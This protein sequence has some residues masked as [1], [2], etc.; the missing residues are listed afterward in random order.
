MEHADDHFGESVAASYD[1][2]VADMFAADVVDPAVDVLAELAGDGRALEFGIGTGRL[3]LPLAQRG[4]PVHGIELSSAMVARLR[5][6]PGGED[7][8]VTLGDFAETSVD[9]EFTLVYL[10]FNTI[11]NLTSQAAQVS[12][13]RN[14]AEHL[15]PGGCFVV[16]VMVP[17]PRGL[18]P[19]HNTVPF[20]TGPPHWG[21]DVYDDLESQTM[22]S[23]H[24]AIGGAHSEHR[25]IPFRYAWPAEL[26]LMAQLAGLHLRTRWD[27]WTRTPF[28]NESRQ[29]VSVWTKPS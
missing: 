26:D 16:E 17:D 27:G 13:F 15:H 4:V 6:K 19:G 12:C 11:M 21:F 8:D 28:T 29:H 10:A 23:H 22:A 2:S 5:E 7:L 24:I 20:L 14:A 25:V 1:D 18:L 3:A 9:G